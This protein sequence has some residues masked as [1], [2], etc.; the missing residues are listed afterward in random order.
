[1]K[2]KFFLCAALAFAST[3]AN[4]VEITDAHRQRARKLVEQ[5]TL[6][7]K[8]RCLGGK[9]SFSLWG[10]ERL[11]IPEIWLADG[12]QGL[13]NHAPHSTLY[14]A[15]ILAAATWNRDIAARYGESLGDDARARGV[16]YSVRSG[17]EHLSLSPLRTQL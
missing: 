10:N 4:A 16:G 14:P 1:M 5:M 12:P 11:G 2:L 17:G 8:I 13:R 6:D 9:T 7:E 3:C 15:G